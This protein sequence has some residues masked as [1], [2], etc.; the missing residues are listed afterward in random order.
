MAGL[1][2]TGL[3]GIF[4][5]LLIFWMII[6]KLAGAKGYSRWRRITPL[7][8]MAAVI[9]MILWGEMWIVGRLVGRL[10]RFG[11]I[12]TFGAPVPG[13]LTIVLALMPLLTLA[14]LLSALHT[15]RLLLSRERG[16]IR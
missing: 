6:R 14:A 2:G 15:A 1:P 4:Y 3:G 12:V 11:D 7:G 10:P 13:T 8:V 5:I 16:D 9:I